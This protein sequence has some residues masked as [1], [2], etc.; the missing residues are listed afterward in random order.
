MAGT[1][2]ES[3][4]T[5]RGRIARSGADGTTIMYMSAHSAEDNDLLIGYYQESSNG[6]DAG[7]ALRVIPAGPHAYYCLADITGNDLRAFKLVAG[8]VTQIAETLNTITAASP[9]SIRFDATTEAGP[10]TRLQIRVWDASLAE[11]GT[12]DLNFTNNDAALQSVAGNPGVA[13]RPH[14]SNARAADFDDVAWT[15]NDGAPPAATRRH[16]VMF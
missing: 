2:A 11:P 14:V 10:V 6:V 9:F 4:A 5:N 8:V 16:V 3:I 7:G 13:A 12:W 1:T 15:N